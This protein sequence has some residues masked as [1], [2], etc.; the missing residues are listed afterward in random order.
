MYKY[1][2]LFLISFLYIFLQYIS[3]LQDRS[4]ILHL[5][6]YCSR[7]LSEPQYPDKK[8]LKLN[9]PKR[10]ITKEEMESMWLRYILYREEK[11][12][13]IIYQI[14]EEWKCMIEINNI[15]IKWAKKILNIWCK[16]LAKDLLNEYLGEYREMEEKEN[17]AYT[18]EDHLNFL[19]EKLIQW[20]T[21]RYYIF[22]KWRTDIFYKTK[23]YKDKDNI[24]KDIIKCDKRYISEK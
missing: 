18:V 12:C 2:L 11:S 17:D 5:D 8:I 7:K 13:E 14:I 10:K 3:K 1:V 6:K 20:E 24:R 22:D 9:N 23:I 21:N 16:E 4:W 15:D 19:N